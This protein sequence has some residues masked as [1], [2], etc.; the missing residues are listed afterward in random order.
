MET[1]GAEVDFTPRVSWRARLFR[2][3]VGLLSLIAFGTFGVLVAKPSASA[4]TNEPALARAEST[5]L[6]STRGYKYAN[7]FC[8]GKIKGG[9]RDVSKDGNG[10][11]CGAATGKFGCDTPEK[12]GTLHCACKYCYSQCGMSGTEWGLTCLPPPIKND[13]CIGKIKGGVADPSK[14]GNGYICDA[15]AGKYGCEAPNN[16]SSLKC[17]CTHCYSQCGMANT[18]WGLTCLPPP[19]K[20]D[21]C[22]GK[23]QAGIADPHKDGNGYICAAAFGKPNCDTPAQLATLECA[24][25]YC[26]SQCGLSRTE[27][28]LCTQS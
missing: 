17:A 4:P 22:V 6:Q 10:F 19:A 14:D 5:H 12:L 21:F 25:K 9:V 27:Y 3:G 23:I 1:R 20:N 7:D 18:E 11:I 13:F 24:C 15:A 28:G 2:G 26:Y 16:I 8:I